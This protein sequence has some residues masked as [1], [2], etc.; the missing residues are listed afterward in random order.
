MYKVSAVDAVATITELRAK[1]SEV[2]EYV[3]KKKVGVLIQKNNEP[4]AVLLDW[5]TYQEMTGGST[6]VNGEASQ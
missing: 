2:L 6:K 3:S 4:C 1:T 5:E